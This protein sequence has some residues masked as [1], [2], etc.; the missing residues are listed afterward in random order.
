MNNNSLL[1]FKN[2]CDDVQSKLSQMEA[3]VSELKLLHFKL[4]RSPNDYSKLFILILFLAAADSIIAI[5]AFFLLELKTAVDAKINELK[6]LSN[7]VPPFI[8]R[9]IFWDDLVVFFWLF[10][11]SFLFFIELKAHLAQNVNLAEKKIK[12]QKIKALNE[13]FKKICV[14]YNQ[15]KAEHRD[16]LRELVKRQMALGRYFL[17]PIFFLT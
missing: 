2:A 15:A 1:E 6:E 7:N 9:N 16:S 8:E 12:V 11:S 17:F 4:V 3:S 10:T 13:Q 5:F 14:D